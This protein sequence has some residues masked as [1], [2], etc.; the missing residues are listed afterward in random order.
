VVA[1]IS[2]EAIRMKEVR[3]NRTAFVALCT[4]LLVGASA[5]AVTVSV[6]NDFNNYGRGDAMT[7]SIGLTHSGMPLAIDGYLVLDLP[8]GILVF[9][10]LAG[11]AIVPHLGTGDPSTWRKLVAN[12]VVPDG[13]NLAPT[14]IFSYAFSGLEPAG[15]WQW[16]FATTVAGTLNVLDLQSASFFVSPTPVHPMLGGWD[17]ET[18][19]PAFGGSSTAVGEMTDGPAGTLLLEVNGS[20]AGFSY[21]YEA[22]AMLRTDGGITASFEGNLFGTLLEGVILGDANGIISGAVEILRVGPFIEDI[23]DIQGM[24]DD[25]GVIHTTHVL[26]YTDGSSGTEFITATHQ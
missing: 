7:T 10:E 11:G 5:R 8:G 24:V 16:I 6:G 18:R 3:V 26:H 23:T 2:L 21:T 19:L 17:I 14:P 20:S 4:A 9:F 1:S 12:V 15:T 13:L 25:D 22:T